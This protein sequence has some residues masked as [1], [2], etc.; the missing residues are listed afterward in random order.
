MRKFTLAAIVMLL[1]SGL[2]S[3]V[4]AEE[5]FVKQPVLLVSGLG[6]DDDEATF[7][8]LEEYLEALYFD[9]EIMRFSNFKKDALASHKDAGQ[10]KVQAAI[11]GKQLNRMKNKY[12]AEKVSIIAHS[13][14]G[15]IVHAYLLNMGEGLDP[16]GSYDNDVSK[17]IFSQV[18]FFGTTA[19]VADVRAMANL[20]DYGVY[21]DVDT[22]VKNLK[23]GSKMLMEMDAA[24][25]RANP[26]RSD[27]Q[28]LTVVSTDDEIVTG[29]PGT[30]AG[31]LNPFVSTPTHRIYRKYGHSSEI[32]AQKPFVYVENMLDENFLAMASFIDGGS[33]Y[34]QTGFTS[35]GKNASL[36]VQ[37]FNR[38]GQGNLENSN[39][40]KLNLLK[41]TA[42][43]IY[44]DNP[45]APARV[46]HTYYNNDAGALTFV[47][48]ELIPGDYSLILKGKKEVRQKLTIDNHEQLSYLFT[49]LKND[50]TKV[51]TGG[52]YSVEDIDVLAKADTVL[53]SLKGLNMKIGFEIYATIR[54]A[55][56]DK[57]DE[58]IL[59]GIY[60]NN[61][62]NWANNG[63]RLEVKLRGGQAGSHS[64]KIMLLVS[65]DK[66][67][68]G[69]ADSG[70]VDEKKSAL[71]ANWK[72]RNEI[73][74]RVIPSDEGG[75]NVILWVNG[76]VF[77]SQTWGPDQ[78]YNPNPVLSI[79]GKVRGN[80]I[81]AAVGTN[82]IILG[83]R[84]ELTGE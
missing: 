6:G 61:N 84:N 38:G 76:T 21:T 54:R 68:N 41:A 63:S 29:L 19:D 47:F 49:P 65:I 22:I 25:R 28:V 62:K 44:G 58:G 30:L 74:L 5:E 33:A 72:A 46:Q 69:N 35:L 82:I 42:K 20:A 51:G 10:L 73:M 56:I 64:G 67:K 31:L 23:A 24:L 80:D 4:A 66:N 50:L 57:F 1:L 77:V 7:G 75:H 12:K 55:D 40:V 14:G 13:Y 60:N 81:G 59:F 11:L 78:Y 83:V 26:Y 48:N 32:S 8:K 52:F 36:N 71:I 53:A 2:C 34:T 70:E 37:F 45:V 18:P 79:G 43:R 15:L 17:V 9:V 39:S 16:N 27:V 3:F